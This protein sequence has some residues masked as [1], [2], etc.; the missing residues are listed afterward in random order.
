MFDSEQPNL[1]EKALSKVAEMG[2]SSQLDE[3]DELDVTIRT[4]PLQLVQGKLDSVT[5]SGEG[6]VMK[7]DLRMESV[8][9]NTGSIAINPAS[10]MVGK[11]ELMEP[12]DADTRIVLSEQDLNRAFNSDYVGSKLQNLT[13]EV[14][15]SSV[16]F[17]IQRA[18]LHLP[19]EGKLELRAD[20]LL[21]GNQETKHFSAVT[22]PRVAS[23]GQRIDLEIISTQEVGLSPELTKALCEKLMQLL[24]IGKFD[25]NGMSMQLRS[26]RAEVGQ[27]TI[28]T[29]TTIEE[30]PSA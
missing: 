21:Q 22:L 25:L 23:D 6:M 16:T 18:D 13:V 17:D 28:N 5:I 10:A 11:I 7:Q 9:V 12:T 3:V 4:N 24:D 1:G 15:D 2:I 14:N 29:L 20:L 30:F 19:G 8:E 27:L 26:L